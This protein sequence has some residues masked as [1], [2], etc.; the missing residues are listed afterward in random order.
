MAGG[1]ERVMGWFGPEEVC[2]DAFVGPFW[3]FE[4][5]ARSQFV[6]FATERVMCGFVVVDDGGGV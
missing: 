4:E 6:V 1:K 3:E 5:V 2:G